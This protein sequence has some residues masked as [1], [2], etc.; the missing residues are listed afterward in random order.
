MVV[1]E[2]AAHGTPSIVVAGE[3]NAATELV[4]QGENGFIAP[5]A[6]AKDLADAVWRIYDAGAEL[7]AKTASWFAR[8]IKQLSLETSLQQVTDAYRASNSERH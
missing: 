3:D 6:S 1:L 4:E 5:S 8:N 7:R 2:A